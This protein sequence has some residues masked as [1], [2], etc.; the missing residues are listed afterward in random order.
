MVNK[1]PRDLRKKEWDMMVHHTQLFLYLVIALA[2]MS[3]AILII[4]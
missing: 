2:V 4:L 3:M 1:K